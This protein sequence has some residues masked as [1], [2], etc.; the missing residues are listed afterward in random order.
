MGAD[1][2][3]LGDTVT[4]YINRNVTAVYDERTEKV[5]TAWLSN[6]GPR[7]GKLTWLTLNKTNHTLSVHLATSIQGSSISSQSG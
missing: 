6:T 4:G 5:A 7:D 2:N 1:T 3:N